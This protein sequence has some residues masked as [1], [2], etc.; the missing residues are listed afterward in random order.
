MLYSDRSMQ[1]SLRDAAQLKQGK[2]SEVSM[3]C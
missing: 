1:L 2:L 3:Y